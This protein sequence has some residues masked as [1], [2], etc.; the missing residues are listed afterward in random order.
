MSGRFCFRIRDLE[1]IDSPGFVR[2][3][4]NRP[5]IPIDGLF[6]DRVCDDAAAVIQ[7]VQIFERCFP[8]IILGYC[9]RFTDFSVFLEIDRDLIR[10]VRFFVS[11][12]DFID[13]HDGLVRFPVLDYKIVLSIDVIR[14]AI[15]L[16][17]LFLNGIVNDPFLLCID[18]HI[19]KGMGPALVSSQ[20]PFVDFLLPACPVLVGQKGDLHFFSGFRVVHPLFGHCNIRRGRSW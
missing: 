2:G 7:T 5:L 9:L 14:I 3:V 19:F 1:I 16:E 4:F 20:S 6:F 8:V 18:R 13:E 17:S 11:R 15:A 12:P 10:A